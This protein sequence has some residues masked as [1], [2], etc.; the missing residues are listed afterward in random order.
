[1]PKQIL[2]LHS[3]KQ[4]LDSLEMVMGNWGYPIETASSPQEL[5]NR[6]RK[7]KPKLL[8]L[9]GGLLSDEQLGSL[10]LLSRQAKSKETVIALL[11]PSPKEKGLTAAH[12]QLELPLNIFTLYEM[13]QK[14]FEAVPRQ[15]VRIKLRLPG[16]VRPGDRH[17]NLGEVLCLSAGGMFIRSG[18][19]I[20]TGTQLEIILPLLGMKRELEITGEVI[21]QVVPTVENNYS[22]GIGIRFENV[23]DDART[24]LEQY[25]EMR[26]VDDLSEHLGLDAGKDPLF[27]WKTG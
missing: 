17:F 24:L 14:C 6:L 23:T 26:L 5:N 8:L 20:A 27:T 19:P 4:F 21:Y 10:P 9:E 22:Q 7:I 12:Y 13:V 15:D 11:G 1:M 3:Q 18:T 16:M 2:A 25:L